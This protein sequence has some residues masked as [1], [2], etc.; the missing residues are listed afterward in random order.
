[1]RRL[2]RYADAVAAIDAANAGD[3]TTVV[4]RGAAEPLALAHGRLAVEWV[5]RLR[6]DAPE[7][8]LLAARAHH[9][10]RWKVPRRSYADGRAG[11][12]R[13]RR[14]Q[15]A[16]H[17]REVAAIL[18]PAGYEADEVARVQS[19]IRRDGLGTD[20][21]A[22]LVEDAACLVFLETQLVA[23]AATLEP[24]HI[25]TVLQKTA[26]KMSPAAVALLAEVPLTDD[27]RAIVGRA[28]G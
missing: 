1:V 16:R 18:G 27:A 6:P 2:S 10:R 14:D 19:L 23:T 3:P 4:V 28:L 11:Y 24:D 20:A 5:Q 12:L 15:K 26:R 21:D 13:W 9:L 17:A 22:Q 8:V 7:E 25:V